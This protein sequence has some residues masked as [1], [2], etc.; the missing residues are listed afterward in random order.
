MV[1]VEPDNDVPYTVDVPEAL[2]AQTEADAIAALDQ[3]AD[4]E[5]AIELGYCPD[6]GGYGYD[7]GCTGCVNPDPQA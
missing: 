3:L 5:E 2:Q 4:L 6:H 7:A 1:R